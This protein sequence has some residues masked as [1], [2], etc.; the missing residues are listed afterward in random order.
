MAKNHTLSSQS[1]LKVKMN[2]ILFITQQVFIEVPGKSSKS[3]CKIPLEKKGDS[4]I[5][6]AEGIYGWIQGDYSGKTSS[7]F[8]HSLSWNSNGG[9]KLQ[10]PKRH[11]PSCPESSPLKRTLQLYKQTGPLNE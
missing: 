8:S 10:E 6:T 3:Y 2:F 5:Y 7:G 11:T 4:G 1:G 9:T